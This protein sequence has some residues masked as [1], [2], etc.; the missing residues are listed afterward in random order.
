MDSE[1]ILKLN[2]IKLPP[3]AERRIAS[4]LQGTLIRE[5]GKLDLKAPTQI[6]IPN[7]G[8]LGI[9]I[10]KLQRGVEVPVL[11]AEEV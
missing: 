4:E 3:E 11:R 8:W 2:G 10:E 1:F 9:W 6:K 5:L 7:K